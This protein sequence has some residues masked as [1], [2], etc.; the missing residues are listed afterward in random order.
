MLYMLQILPLRLHLLVG[1]HLDV[2]LTPL[3]AIFLVDRYEVIE[4]EGIGTFLL[5][6]RQNANEHQ[7]KTLCFVELQGSHAMPPTEGPETSVLTFLQ[8]TRHAGDRDAHTNNVMVGSV[9]VFNQ[10]KHIHV[11]H[12]EIH[13]QILVNLAFRHLRIAIE[14]V[15]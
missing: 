11:E 15:K 1:F 7:V 2:R 12:R 10:T 4:Q 13:L 3:E 9:L 6:F 14:V 5:I 8:G